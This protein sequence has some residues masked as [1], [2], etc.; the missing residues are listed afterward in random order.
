MIQG[1]ASED[2]NV[3]GRNLAFKA[4]PATVYFLWVLG[5]RDQG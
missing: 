1:E 5:L 4:L 3:W 2:R